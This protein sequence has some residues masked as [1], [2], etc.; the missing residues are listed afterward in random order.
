MAGKAQI[1]RL[2]AAKPR[3]NAELQHLC[4]DH[5]GSIARTMSKLIAEG[6][7]RIIAGGGRGHPATYAIS[8]NQQ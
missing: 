3:T 5:G 6:R 2:L 8:E 4:V 1:R 7:A